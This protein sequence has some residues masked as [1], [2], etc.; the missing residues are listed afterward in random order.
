VSVGQTPT[1]KCQREQIEQYLERYPDA[2]PTQI[3]GAL[4]L[5]PGARQL[6]E[7]VDHGVDP[8]EPVSFDR[9]PEWQ[10]KSV[11][12]GEEEY[13]ASA[14]TGVE[15]VETID[16]LDRLLKNTKLG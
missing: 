6:I 4:G 9:P 10:V 12:V 13:P 16:Y 2:T 3:M 5:P 14:G 15:M 7:E 8:S 11:T 1:E